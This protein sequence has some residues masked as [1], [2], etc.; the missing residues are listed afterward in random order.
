MNETI[1][2]ANKKQSLFL[3]YINAYVT[4]SKTDD[5]GSRTVQHL[6]VVVHIYSV[7]A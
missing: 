2:K 6:G 5:N 1:W 4:H 3:A 7:T